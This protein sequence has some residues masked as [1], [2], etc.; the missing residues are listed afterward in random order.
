MFVAEILGP[1][2]V[3]NPSAINKYHLGMVFVPPICQLFDDLDVSW[4]EMFIRE[5]H[6][7]CISLIWTSQT[8]DLPGTV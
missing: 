8:G 2:H 7:H 1:N 3:V 6:V 5:N 4:A